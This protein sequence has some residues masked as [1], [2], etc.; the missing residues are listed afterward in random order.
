M[1]AKGQDKD[2]SREIYRWLVKHLATNVIFAA[3]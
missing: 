3:E 1:E 2:V